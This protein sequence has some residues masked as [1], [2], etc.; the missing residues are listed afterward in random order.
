MLPVLLCFLLSTLNNQAKKLLWSCK[1]VQELNSINLKTYKS[2]E[3]SNVVRIFNIVY[4]V[5]MVCISIIRHCKQHCGPSF[6]A[7]GHNMER[8]QKQTD[9]KDNIISLAYSICS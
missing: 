1:S 7:N 8:E 6:E 5:T 4:M 9:M 2:Y 3:I